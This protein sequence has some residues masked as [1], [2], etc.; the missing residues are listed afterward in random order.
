VRSPW[1]R[2][3][4]RT[5]DRYIWGIE[6]SAYAVEASAL[7]APGARVL[8]LGCGEGRDSV[9]FAGRGLTVTGVDAS[10]AGLRKAERLARARGLDVRWLHCDM[11]R[12]GL[13]GPFDLV[14]SCGAVHYVAR[15][16]RARLLP[17]L[18]RLTR[19]GGYHAHVV[20]TDRAIY[21]EKGEHIDYFAPG[22]LAGFYP[23]WR[24]LWREETVIPCAQDGTP[25]GHSVEQ[26]VAQAPPGRRLD[27]RPPGLTRGGPPR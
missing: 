23:T 12:L 5:P 11:A 1:A 7:L 25:H 19:P 18:M 14:Y 2:E 17:L 13:R 16:A 3:Y 26:V 6:P 21:V 9:F 24:V 15:R 27:R 8:D 20:F 22:E 4:E 10:L